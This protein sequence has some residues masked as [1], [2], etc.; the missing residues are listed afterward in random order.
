MGILGNA[1]NFD[2]AKGDLEKIPGFYKKYLSPFFNQGINSMGIYSKAL[3]GMIGDPTGLEDNIMSHYSESP[4][5]QYQTKNVTDQ[6]NR[7]AAIGGEVGTPNE[8]ADMAGRVQGVV[9]KD[10]QDYLHN[11]MQPY[12]TALSGEGHLTDLGYNAGNNIAKMY[13]NLYSNE[14]GM[15]ASKDSWYQQMMG[16]GLGGIGK[17]LA[18]HF[19]G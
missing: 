13:G 15:D 19:M 18:Q 7:A 3:A 2:D 1:F 5:A 16:S 17:L 9:S 12:E 8:Q 14:A 6:L 10:Q 11:A 4:Y